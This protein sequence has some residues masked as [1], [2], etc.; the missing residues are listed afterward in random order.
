VAWRGVR[1]SI[2][3]AAINRT[4]RKK[5]RIAKNIFGPAPG[6]AATATTILPY[7]ASLRRYRALAS[8][9]HLRCEPATNR[10][11][12]KSHDD[13]AQSLSPHS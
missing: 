5:S 11:A 10:E 1:K 6:Y 3:V 8:A 4:P 9:P 7:R 2:F 12:V 13:H